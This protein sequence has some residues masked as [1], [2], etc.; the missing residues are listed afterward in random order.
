MAIICPQCSEIHF[1]T[2]GAAP[3]SHCRKCEADL[4]QAAGILP[5]LDIDENGK[6]EP[7]RIRTGKLFMV[8]GGV[9]IVL[10]VALG[11][12]GA[13]RYNSV[14]ETM[15]IVIEKKDAKGVDPSHVRETG[16]AVYKVGG[17]ERYIYPGVRMLGVQFPVYYSPS[18]PDDANES[19]P[20]MH[21]FFAVVMF[22]LGSITL[23]RGVLNF[24]VARARESDLR[25]VM[26]TVRV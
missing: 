4:N 9:L 18:N 8:I 24:L 6:A 17:K 7:F 22:L 14:K 21:M 10:G 3:P 19:R 26:R 20:W 2:N 12:W 13:Y 23:V 15:A 16:T 25:K 1:D 5:T 11:S